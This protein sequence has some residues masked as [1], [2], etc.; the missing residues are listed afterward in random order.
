VITQEPENAPYRRNRQTAEDWAARL[1]DLCAQALRIA[2]TVAM[3]SHG[4]RRSGPGESFWQFRPYRPGDP[5]RSIDWRRSAQGDRHFVR[6]Q[7]W[8][9]AESFW[10]WLDQSPSMQFSGAR[11]RQTKLDRASVLLFAM[12]SL[13]LRSGERVGLLCAD[14]T[15][16]IGSGQLAL[17]RLCE[18]L[19]EQLGAAGLPIAAELPRHAT[20]LAFSDTW[21][22]LDAWDRRLTQLARPGVRGHV[23]QVIDPVEARL[24]MRGRVRVEG[25]EGEAP[26]LLRRAESLADAYSTR[27]AQHND[28]M[29]AICRRLGW[30]FNRHLTDHPPLPLL[31]GLHEAI[32]VDR[33]SVHA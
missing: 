31:L 1:P 3:G 13:L 30:G 6:E 12:A 4:R 22:P 17:D 2:A 29:S 28:R 16:M 14:R 15:R 24:T 9:A 5:S 11:S 25:L 23:V 18:M 8:Q 20:V 19:P 33:R 7:E 10:L 21:T 32:S 26:V 27:F